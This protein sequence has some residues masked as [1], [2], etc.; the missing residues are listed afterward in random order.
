[1]NRRKAIFWT[2][3]IYFIIFT[4]VVFGTNPELLPEPIKEWLKIENNNSKEDLKK[5]IPKKENKKVD[6]A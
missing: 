6:R 5:E 4:G 2:A 3:A 1:M